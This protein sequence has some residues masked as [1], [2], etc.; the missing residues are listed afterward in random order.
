M[1][2]VYPP[3]SNLMLELK[4][5]LPCTL[6]K[7]VEL[8]RSALQQFSFQTDVTEIPGVL[9][10]S[11]FWKGALFFWASYQNSGHQAGKYTVVV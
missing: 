4:A 10:I 5:C 2:I 6:Y 9:D 1:T 11:K 3:T 7:D 8:E